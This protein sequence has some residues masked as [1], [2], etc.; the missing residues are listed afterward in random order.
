MYDIEQA[1]LIITNVK[2]SIEELFEDHKR[3]LQ[4]QGEQASE[5]S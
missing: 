2:K 4:P 5:S 3:R 1:S